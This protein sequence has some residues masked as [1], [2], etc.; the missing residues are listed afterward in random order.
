MSKPPESKPEAKPPVV[1]PP[2]EEP[3]K[4]EPPKEEP[5]K[6]EPPK[7]EPP[8]EE[9]PKEEPPK[10]EPPKEELP[11]KEEESVTNA[12]KKDPLGLNQSSPKVEPAAGDSADNETDRSSMPKRVSTGLAARMGGLDLSKVGMI[13]GPRPM[14]G[15]LGGGPESS[16]KEPKTVSNVATNDD[17]K[18]EVDNA[19]NKA[20]VKKGGRKAP[21]RKAFKADD[22]D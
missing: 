22:D 2:K 15:S 8:K 19:L 21:T 16:P 14:C 7:E 3:P 4:E 13:G 18:V 20:T 17:G 12:M 1:Q 11:K 5:P 6:E 10:E 9:P